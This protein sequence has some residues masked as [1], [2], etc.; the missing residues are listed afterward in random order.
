M[1]YIGYFDVFVRNPIHNFV[2]FWLMRSSLLSEIEITDSVADLLELED[3]FL[4]VNSNNYE[5]FGDNIIEYLESNPL[6][7]IYFL[8]L[9]YRVSEIVPLRLFEIS[10]IYSKI[11]EHTKK[12]IP[13]SETWYN[14]S[15]LKKLL[16]EKQRDIKGYP[17]AKQ[18][19]QKI[20]DIYDRETQAAEYYIAHDM[21]DELIDLTSDSNFYLRIEDLDLAAKFAAVKCFKFIIQ[22][23]VEEQVISHTVESAI[24]GGS[25][26]ILRIAMN[27]KFDFSHAFMYAIKYHRNDV[28]DWIKENMKTRESEVKTLD[29][30]EWM[31][32]RAFIYYMRKPQ[33][34]GWTRLDILMSNGFHDITVEFVQRHVTAK[35]VN[36]VYGLDG[37]MLKC[38]CKNAWLDVVKLLIEKGA[39]KEKFQPLCSAIWSNNYE[40]VD[41]MLSI[42]CKLTSEIVQLTNNPEMK[43]YLRKILFDRA[44][45]Y[46]KK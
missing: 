40:V 26:E 20:C 46:K 5:E 17:D 15:P 27:M 34:F 18:K 21:V 33:T 22:N 45:N 12:N 30:L 1:L 23:N 16:N 14:K 39:D 29:C 41:Y 42:G 9:A 4:L 6:T 8:R 11:V 10:E 13:V 31:N 24:Q 28:A 2:V 19:I 38:A 32:T 37:T 25:L 43:N 44:A 36:E 3:S 7:T 35:N